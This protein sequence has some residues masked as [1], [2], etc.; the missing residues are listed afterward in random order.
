MRQRLSYKNKSI[1]GPVQLFIDPAHVGENRKDDSSLASTMMI[2]KIMKVPYKEMRWSGMF[3]WR[4][5][6]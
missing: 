5:L 1:V 2:G 3:E 6:K 4:H